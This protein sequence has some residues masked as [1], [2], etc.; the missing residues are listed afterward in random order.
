MISYKKYNTNNKKK[1]V[2][3]NK[4]LI[5]YKNT[6]FLKQFISI[7][8]KILPRFITKLTAKQQRKITKSIKISRIVGLLKFVNN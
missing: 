3:F 2:Y 5:N 1:T 7:E 8:G 6:D 4:E